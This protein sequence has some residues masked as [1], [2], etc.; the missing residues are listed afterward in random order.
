MTSILI[1]DDH[2]LVRT[3]LISLF[4]YEEDLSCIGEAANTEEALKAI[5]EKKPD[6]VLVDLRLGNESGFDLFE[7]VSALNEPQCKFIIL[8]SSAHLADFQKAKDV[9]AYG[10][11]LKEALPEELLFAIRLVSSGRKYYDPGIMELVMGDNKEEDHISSLT[12]KEIEVLRELGTGL[13]NRDIASK[14]FI[15]ENTVKKHVSQILDKLQLSDRTQAAL[16][17]NVKGLATFKV[18]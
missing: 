3:G 7:S 1:V 9:G 18:E 17:A 14:L 16:F 11:I 8:T 5:I 4:S 15:S 6:I 13:S 2:P 12:P 10:Y